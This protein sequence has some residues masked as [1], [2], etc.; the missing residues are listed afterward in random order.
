M[1][2]CEECIHVNICRKMNKWTPKSNNCDDYYEKPKTG[3]WI[4]EDKPW[5][6]FGD[7]VLVNTCSECGESFM[8]HGNS[9][10]FCPE[11]GADMRGADDEQV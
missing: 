1:I 11:C 8:Y 4:K 10:K 2:K 6:G 7:C 5:G 3:K 9:P